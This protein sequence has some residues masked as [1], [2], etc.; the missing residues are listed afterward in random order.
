VIVPPFPLKQEIVNGQLVTTTQ[1]LSQ[2]SSICGANNYNSETNTIEFVITGNW[3]CL[4]RVRQVNNVVLTTHLSLDF[5]SFLANDKFGTF[6]NK[7]AAFLD[8]DPAR[9]K[10]VG[11]ARG[12]VIPK[13][14]ID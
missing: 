3:Q 6:V 9:V 4:V 10:V 7:I 13:V 14:L 1:N 5:D 8:L 11:V 2:K 12:S